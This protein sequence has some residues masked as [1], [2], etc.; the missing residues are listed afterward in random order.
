[1]GW[2]ARC[3]TTGVVPVRIDFS[4]MTSD[5]AWGPAC[6]AWWTWPG[7]A[8]K[9]LALHVGIQDLLLPCWLWYLGV[10][11]PVETPISEPCI[12]WGANDQHNWDWGASLAS[13][14]LG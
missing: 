14:Q 4:L 10:G 11:V 13:I 3:Y 5:S 7:P 9:L 2:V 12:F 8:S 6:P 1:M